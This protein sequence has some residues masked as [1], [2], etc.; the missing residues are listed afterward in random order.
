MVSSASVLGPT[1]QVEVPSA[2]APVT[3]SICGPSAA[4]S[5]DGLLLPGTETPPF[6][7]NSSPAKLTGLPSSSGISTD[8]YS[9]RWR[10]GLS[11]E[12]PHIDSTTILCERP[13]PRHS[14]ASPRLLM[15]A[16]VLSACCASIIGWRG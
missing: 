9:L 1:H 3:R 12:R 6:T 4:T 11:Y 13:M 16:C 14:P 5:T 10:T 15:A 7:R 8:R 2:S